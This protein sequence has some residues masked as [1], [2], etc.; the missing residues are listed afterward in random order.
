MEDTKR[1][2]RL[3]S[4][5]FIELHEG[6]TQEEVEER[7]LGALPEGMDCVSLRSQYWSE[8]E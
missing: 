8:E 2:V 6:E 3:E 5:L 1:Y 7:Y 4:V